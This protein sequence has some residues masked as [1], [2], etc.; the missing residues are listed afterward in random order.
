[1]N[2][3]L[4]IDFETRSA[5]DLRKVGVHVYATHPTTDIWMLAYAFDDEGVQVW[6]PGQMFPE[7][8]CLHVLAGGE[9]RAWNAQ[10]E[11]ILWREVLT[12][13]HG[14]PL[15]ALEQFHCTMVEASAMALPRSLEKAAAVL[16]VKNRKDA[17][18]YALMLRMCRPRRVE[19]DGTVVWWDEPERVDRLAEYCMNDVR[20][21]RDVAKRTRRLSER[22]RELYLLDQRVNDQG[23]LLDLELVEAAHRMAAQA[24][25]EANA[26]LS[27]LTGGEVMGVTKRDALLKWLQDK[28]LDAEDVTKAT[29]RD[30]LASDAPGDTSRAVLEIRKSAARSSV[31]K[32][33]SMLRSHGTDGRARGLLVFNAASTGRWAGSR[34]QP[35]NFP[36]GE[37]PKGTDVETLLEAILA[38]YTA[39]VAEVAPPLVAISS[40]LR[41]MLVASPGHDLMSADFKQIE[42]R[43]TA[44]IAEQNDLVEAFV[45][46]KPIYEEMAADIYKVP[47]SRVANPSK[48]RD[49]G[50]FT[51]LG[52]GYGM[53]AKK[54]REQL[55]EQTGIVLAKEKGKRGKVIRDEA[56][57]AVDAYRAR[58]SR[59]VK[60]WREIERAALS[61]VATPGRVTRCGRRG[62][63]RFVVR[64]QFLWCV[65]PSGRPLAY[66]LP[67]IEMRKTP[68]G[69]KKASVV[70]SGTNA[71]TRRWEPIVAYGG[72]LTENVVQAMSRD[73]MAEAMLR[74]DAAGYPLVLTVHDEI[75]ADVPEGHGSLDEFLR[76]SAERPEWALDLPIAVEGWQGRRYRK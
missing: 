30:L 41:N 47:V 6:Y 3:T 44:W 34:I 16:R 28:G 27:R 13:R 71:Y 15:P 46:G 14:F 37:L 73:V 32:L 33:D 7:R 76:L 54:F 23:V 61:A 58:N 39:E 75:V 53:G 5:L 42:A 55:K 25:E 52:C 11:R 29:V 65:L 26:E 35:Q 24:T 9:I 67:R 8:L 63:I 51:V 4:S 18:G 60:F 50:K 59:I 57:E 62:C 43:V 17:K 45:K 38:G 20:A 31:A 1:M 69:E 68:W 56:K 36:K 2:T 22:E 64:G 66:P 10:F 19:E 21:E 40:T 48:E 70:Y 72:L 74:H 49:V 12:P